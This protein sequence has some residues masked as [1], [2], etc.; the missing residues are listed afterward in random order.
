MATSTVVKIMLSS[1]CGDRFPLS[2]AEPR[3]LSEIRIALKKFIEA[4]R[5]LGNPLYEVWINEDQTGD[6]SKPAWDHCMDQAADC[7]IFIA[8]FTGNA[9]WEDA[10]GTV[11]ICHAE[12]EKAYSLAP[13]K[14][15]IVNAHEKNDS[16]APARDIDIRFQQYVESLRQFEARNVSDEKRLE[17]AVYRTLSQATVRMVQRGVQ[18]ASLGTNHVGPALDWS[19]LSYIANERTEC[20]WRR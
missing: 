15:F 18:G 9:G 10:A 14:V 8:I 2:T 6:G 7:D 5:P 11:G 19:R 17:T 20:V 13:G 12:L 16:A 1:R 4:A 3:T